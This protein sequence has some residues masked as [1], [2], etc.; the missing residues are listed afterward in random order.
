[1]DHRLHIIGLVLLFVCSAAAAE[2]FV[3]EHSIGKRQE[4]LDSN[5]RYLVEWEAYTDTQTIVF[6]LT[7]QTVGYVGFGISPTG[8]MAGADIII[9]G[10]HNTNDT[11]YFSVR[12]L[13]YHIVYLA[14][15]IVV[16]IN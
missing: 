8:G 15:R 3:G 16:S 13:P 9:G 12:F 1:M 6:E 10:V 4:Y 2:D 14:T 11:A 7:V 5:G